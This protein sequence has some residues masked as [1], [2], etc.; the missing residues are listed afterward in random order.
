MTP[1]VSPT[2]LSPLTPHSAAMN[3]LGIPVLPSLVNALILISIF[4]T[5]NSFTFTASRAMYG[6]SQRGQAPPILGRL[7]RQGVPYV[8]VLV[9]LLFGCLAFLQVSAGTAKVL[10]WWISLVGAAQLVTW[11]CIA[12]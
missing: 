4:S 6:L 2:P 8:A 5:A 7:N 9:S 12:M 11:T 3:R 10:N 1:L